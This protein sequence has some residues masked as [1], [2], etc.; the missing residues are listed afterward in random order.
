MDYGT[1]GM[2]GNRITNLNNLLS[3]YNSITSNSSYS[4]CPFYNIENEYRVIVLNNRIELIYKKEL[5]I[6]YGNNKNTIK[7]LLDQFN[8]NYFK[9]VNDDELKRVLKLNEKYIYSWKFNLSNGSK[10]SLKIK[11]DEK[12]H[13]LE[14][15]NDI[16]NKINVGFCSIDIIKTIDNK[17]MILEINSGVM[18][19]NFIQEVT[20]GYD[21]AKIIY[22]KA[23]L[24]MFK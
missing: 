3:F 10:P 5:P 1:C 22:T 15:V 6:V 7:E 12:K 8:F 20:N 18:M 23:I 9:N 2:N 17:Y 24:E 21:I 4:I 19:K 14:I 11:D 13:I 16:L